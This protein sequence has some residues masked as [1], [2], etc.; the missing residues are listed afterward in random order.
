M[1]SFL[2]CSSENETA[3]LHRLDEFK[4]PVAI[5]ARTPTSAGMGDIGREF[6]PN[7]ASVPVFWKYLETNF[8]ISKQSLMDTQKYL[9]SHAP[10]IAKDNL[11]GQW[12]VMTE[13]I[14]KCLYRML[15]AYFFVLYGWQHKRPQLQ[16]DEQDS[17]TEIDRGKCH[18]GNTE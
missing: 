14:V 1:K 16:R 5:R 7:I 18:G 17:A 11:N 8:D 3:C 4:G 15:G 2:S 9:V 12:Y 10:D 6:N 13:R